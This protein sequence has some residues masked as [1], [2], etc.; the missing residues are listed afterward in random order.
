MKRLLVL[1]PFL[2]A[3][4]SCSLIIEAVDISVRRSRELG[5]SAVITADGFT[6]RPPQASLY[7]KKNFPTPGGVTLG[8]TDTFRDGLVYFVTPFQSATAR[9]T[10]EAMDEWNGRPG[11]KGIAVKV[12]EKKETSYVGR[13]ATLAVVDIPRGRGGQVAAILVVKQGSGFLILCAGDVYY[14]P[15]ARDRTLARNKK[16]LENLMKVTTL[17]KP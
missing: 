2:F 16:A 8:P 1:L 6:L 9:S 3:L 11:R 13:K 14:F 15:Q 4:N 10:N 7:P 5:E 12:I 17:T